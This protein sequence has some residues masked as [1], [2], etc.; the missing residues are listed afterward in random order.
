[1]AAQQVVGLIVIETIDIFVDELRDF[2]SNGKLINAD[3]WLQNQ[4][5]A[6]TRIS[7]RLEQRFEERQIWAR[8]KELGIESGVAGA[9]S[10]IPQILISLIM[11]MPAFVLAMI[12]EST[13]SVV[14]CVRILAS[15]DANKLDSIGI[16]LAGTAST[17]VGVYVSHVVSKAIMAVPLLKTFDRQVSAVFA[18][19]LV[20]AVPLTAIY[21]FDQSKSKLKFMLNKLA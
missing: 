21:T 7:Q 4:K 9:L 1:M 8:A 15:S 12:R 17:I 6:L 16:I 18:G 3:G 2:A 13:L 10:V 11:R 19:L 20:T 14:R 5:D